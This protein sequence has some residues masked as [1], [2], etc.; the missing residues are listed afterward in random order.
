MLPVITTSERK[1]FKRCHQRWWWGYRDGL[2]PSGAVSSKLWF[3]GGMHIVLAHWY[4]PGQKRRKDW[5]DVWED[6]C[7]NDDMSNLIRERNADGEKEWVDARVLGRGMMDGYIDTY[8]RDRQWDVVFTEEPMKIMI[9]HPTIAGRT[10]GIFQTT[11][12]GVVWDR[13]EDCF[14]LLEHKTAAAIQTSH[15]DLDEQ[16][17]A[18]WALATTV[19]RDKG[20]LSSKER[21][22][23]IEYNFLRKALPPTDRPRNAK[24]LYLNKN[25]SISKQQ[26]APFFHR[27]FVTR[28]RVE[29]TT[30]VRRIAED[31]ATMR[32]YRAGKLPLSK[33]PTR[34]CMWDCDFFALC[35]L[36]EQ[37]AEWREFR[38]SMFKV[39]D[40]YFMYRKTTED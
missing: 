9:P 36:H 11:F 30:Q 25:G 8:G 15:L 12:D 14:K 23:G 40:P 13:D 2:K 20:I 19:L 29:N 26:P 6:F 35:K 38:D 34:D 33:N 16:A 18:M 3:G 24:G 21:I 7:D 31:M 5:P 10:V 1:A 4:G 37:G 28:T 39:T 27:E 32:K 17:G 22:A